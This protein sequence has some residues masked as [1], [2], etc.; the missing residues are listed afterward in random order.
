MADSARKLGLYSLTDSKKNEM[1]SNGV[2]EREYPFKFHSA[3]GKR[4]GLDKNQREA[5]KKISVEF[6]LEDF[7]LNSFKLENCFLKKF[8]SS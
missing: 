4:R 3:S 8:W 5:T 2:N 7:G 1:E 6:F